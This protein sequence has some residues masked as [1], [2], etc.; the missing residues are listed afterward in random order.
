MIRRYIEVVKN[1]VFKS[2]ILRNAIFN[3]GGWMVGVVLN[4]IATPYIFHKMGV[5][6]FGIYVLIT[7]LIS[8]LTIM[9]FG[10]GQSI[11][12]FISEFHAV[13]QYDKINLL[14][15]NALTLLVFV[16]ITVALLILFF[17]TSL[18]SFFKIP[19]ILYANTY[20]AI[21][22]ASVVFFFTF[23]IIGL[24]S[25]INGLQRFDIS[26][27][28]TLGT[29][30]TLLIATI[31][32]LYSGGTLPTIMLVNV[33]VLLGSLFIYLNRINKLIPKYRFYFQLK[34]EILAPP[35]RYGGYLIISRLSYLALTQIDKL[36]IAS[37]MGAA[38]VS[39]Y[40]VP[41][42][43]LNALL[44][45]IG[46]IGA[47]LTPRMSELTKSGSRNMQVELYINATYYLVLFSTP[48]FLIF[49][50]LSKRVMGLWMGNE[51]AEQSWF[52][53]SVIGFSYYLS[54]TVNILWSVALGMGKSKQQAFFT[55]IVI[56]ITFT[57]L[58]PMT[59]E[60]G[61]K[62][63]AFAVLLSSVSVPLT[64]F[65]MNRK[66]FF[67][68]NKRFFCKIF[69]VPFVASFS[70]VLATWKLNTA[71]NDSFFSFITL[72][73]SILI[74]Y[75]GVVIFCNKFFKVN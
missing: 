8:Y 31:V 13:R 25:V 33:F 38:A 28:I 42:R 71:L 56:I 27:K 34:K 18:I 44:L 45:G 9:D 63:A 53:M 17:N 50:L 57:A 75:A 43:L 21:I 54:A 23:I 19:Q 11:I 26:S 1:A 55:L 14:I 10:I 66:F 6:S 3:G 32:I 24:S 60:W 16:G 22:Y 65:Y 46:T 62:G 69:L 15:N 73:F 20:K 12:K 61:L 2:K 41:T 67:V 52:L 72:S 35:L 5:D 39:Y 7:A 59:K 4:F 40:A 74:I 64:F 48:V 47:V 49:I 29:N 68:G 70:C 58:Y 37:I 30:I 51:F 36:F